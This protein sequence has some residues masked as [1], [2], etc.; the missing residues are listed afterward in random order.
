MLKYGD[1]PAMIVELWLDTLTKETWFGK[2]TWA[3]TD[4]GEISTALSHAQKLD[5]YYFFLNKPH[6]TSIIMQIFLGTDTNPVL[7]YER[8]FTQMFTTTEQE[9]ILF[10]KASELYELVITW[11][12]SRPSPTTHTIHH[13]IIR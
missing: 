10:A 5:Q 9:K 2:R 12:A 8:L 13:L 1:I 11:P 6:A 7:V 4:T 3:K